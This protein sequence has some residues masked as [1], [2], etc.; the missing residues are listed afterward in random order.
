V[1]PVDTTAAGDSFNA[2]F[3][4]ARLSGARLGAALQDGAALA[5]HV[6]SHPGALV[7]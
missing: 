5:G 3:L 4:A 2:G 1:A 6:V 7:G